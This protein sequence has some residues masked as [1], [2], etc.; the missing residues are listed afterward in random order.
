SVTSS[1]EKIK[2]YTLLGDYPNTMAL[3][4]GEVTSNV[5]D[6]GFADVKVSNTAFKPLVREAKFDLGELAIVTYLQAKA[7]GKPYVLIPATVLGRGQHHTIAYNP[8]RGPLNAT[9]LMGKRVGVR[10]YTQTTGAWVRG[11]LADDYGVDPTKVHW[12]TFEDPHLAEFKDPGFV[13]R[14]PESKTLAQML[15][16]GE[17]DAAIVGDKLPDP[18]L[19]PLIPDA[20]AVAR[21]WAK[22]HGGVPINHMMVV[23]DTL[24]RSR[25]DLVTEIY[26]MLR[27]SR[28][29]VPPPPDGS[30]LDPWRFGVEANRRSLEI[31]VDYSFRQKLIPRIFSVEE[32]FDDC[33][34]ALV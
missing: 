29:A 20:D 14:A 3:K 15:L 4:K 27:E 10:A 23:R 33:T 26:R 16:D 17:L 22:M 28:R 6:L 19:A 1:V 2:L 8:Q 11:F 5:I 18:R 24:S 21:K 7:Y 12:V 25:P 30:A 31:I 9:D 34:R 32:L 13:T